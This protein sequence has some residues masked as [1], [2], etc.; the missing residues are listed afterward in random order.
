MDTLVKTLASELATQVLDEIQKKTK[1]QNTILTEEEIIQNLRN[2]S[3]R[4]RR[5][6]SKAVCKN[7]TQLDVKQCQAS[8]RKE[9]TIQECFKSLSEDSDGICTEVYNEPHEPQEIST[10]DFHLEVKRP[11]MSAFTNSRNSSGVIP[12]N[13][14]P[15]DDIKSVLGVAGTKIENVS[16]WAMSRSTPTDPNVSMTNT[17]YVKKMSEKTYGKRNKGD[18]KW[19]VHMYLPYATQTRN[20]YAGRLRIEARFKTLQ[21]ALDFRDESLRFHGLDIIINSANKWE[22][23][24]VDNTRFPHFEGTKHHTPLDPSGITM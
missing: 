17:P 20:M 12:P 5:S 24:L 14:Q 16:V 19:M 7:N 15:C 13:F 23:V 1:T 3:D 21:R 18:K 11:K 10:S 8:K 22:L 2:N 4:L 6:E 9:R